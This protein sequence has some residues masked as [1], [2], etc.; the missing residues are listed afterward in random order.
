MMA[1]KVVTFSTFVVDYY[2][3]HKVKRVGGNS[4]NF[5]IECA[6]RGNKVSVVGAVGNEES[7]DF[8]I[9]YL[10]KYG[11]DT[12]HLH[13]LNGRTASNRLL[14]DETG[15]RYSPDGAWHGGVYEDFILSPADW[16]YI[17]S[18]DMIA[19]TCLG[20]NFTR[21]FDH[22]NTQAKL[23]V[24]FMHTADWELWRK[25]RSRSDI[26]FF[27]GGPKLCGP[28]QELAAEYNKLIVVTMGARGSRAFLG[29]TDVFSPAP[30]V[31]AVIDTTGCG[32]VFQAAFSLS[33]SRTHDLRQA[34]AAGT[35]AAAGILC[36]LG[37]S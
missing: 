25:Y 35:E 16:D 26:S 3:V 1:M 22:I 8:I 2:P 9:A 15:D 24:D 12:S 18:F 20:P 31:E 34:L 19:T 21:V 32:D 29:T 13:R 17:N 7:G 10:E 23:V 11:I 30:T 28:A 27:S 36:V 4:A 33:W 6:R 37:G 5:A 14:H